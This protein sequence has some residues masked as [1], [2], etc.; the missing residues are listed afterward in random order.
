MPPRKA[1]AAMWRHSTSWPGGKARLFG[2]AIHQAQEQAATI[3]R[4]VLEGGAGVVDHVVVGELDVAR[5]EAHREAQCL[6]ELVPQVE[7]PACAELKP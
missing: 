5:G 3:L 6:G 2:T 1:P 4:C 7:R